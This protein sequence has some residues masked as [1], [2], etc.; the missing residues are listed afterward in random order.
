MIIVRII[1][2]LTVIAEKETSKA[3][4][5]NIAAK[6]LHQIALYCTGLPATIVSTCSIFVIVSTL[7]QEQWCVLFVTQ[8]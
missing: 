3:L 8:Q 1:T 6:V 7:Q 5:G 2:S 4:N